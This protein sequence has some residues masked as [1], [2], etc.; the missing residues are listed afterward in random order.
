MNSPTKPFSLLII[1]TIIITSCHSISKTYD[2]I[3]VGGGT[4]G[5]CAA[6]QS[7]RMGT[8]TLLLEKYVWLG[9]MLTSAGVSAIDGNN[10]MPG[11]L[12]GEFKDSL[13][14]HYGSAKALATGWVSSVQFEPS[15]G[16]AIFQHIAAKQK[17][18]TCKFNTTVDKIVRQNNGWQLTINEN[19]KSKVV[20]A[21]YV[22]DATELGDIAKT[23]GLPYSVGFDSSSD[24]HE[25]QA[26]SKA[27]NIVQDMTFVMTLKRYDTPQ[28]IAR[29]E[30]YDPMEFCNCCVNKYNVDSL[31]YQKPWSADM[32]LSYGRLPNNK[33]MINWPMYGNDI[34]MND[35]EYTPAQRDSLHRIAKA[36]T[37]RF[38]YFMQ[39]ELGM[40]NLGLADDEY[41]T[42]DKMPF[43]P[44]YREG[45]RFKGLVQF[46]LE[47]ILNQYNLSRPL[48]RTDIGVGDYPVDHHH[49]EYIKTKQPLP[50]I[51][52]PH[53]TSFG[54]PL[55]IIIPKNEDHLLLAE[56][57]VSV[58]NL[59][60]GTTRLQPVSM[61]IGQAAGA[62]ASL[63]V[64]EK[65]LPRNVSVHEVQRTLLDAGGY[66]QPYL[67]VPKSDP[68]FKSMQ[69]IGVMGILHGLGKNVSWQNETWFRADTLLLSK[70]L[71]GLQTVYP[72][73]QLPK[74]EAVNVSLKTM[75]EIMTSIAKLE[76]LS[77][78]EDIDQQV[79]S[80]FLDYKLGEPIDSMFITRK[81]MA[82]LVDCIL[83]P[84]EN[85]DVNIYGELK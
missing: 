56:K 36:K 52:F 61:Q 72:K 25:S 6:I 10:R 33:Y 67:D 76:G 8:K 63:A 2:V 51:K 19:G 62:L 31:S 37:I 65:K 75:K 24:T 11:G 53:I 84:F 60:N 28:L 44:Y 81:Q 79:K 18:L 71:E 47:D 55:G 82:V 7:A 80:I 73:L 14:A 77:F 74:S 22:I 4:S 59:V 40:T 21:S 46:N 43:I 15:V 1:L 39:H 5:T 78:K 69:R 30:G 32:M 83:H 12:W 9:G 45:R 58:T 85:K 49:N 29:P 42:A 35:I 41:P 16:N 38:L 26:A 34:Y 57:A 68:S 17:T 27:V 3:V 70:E 23:I 54:V 48:F 50:A 64:K 66:L 13:I 20:K